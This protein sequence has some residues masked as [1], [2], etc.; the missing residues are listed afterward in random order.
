MELY[1]LIILPI[2]TSLLLYLLPGKVTTWLWEFP[3]IVI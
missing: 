3:C 2:F 1:F